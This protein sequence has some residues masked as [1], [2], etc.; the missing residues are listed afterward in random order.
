MGQFR[1]SGIISS[2]SL[3]S[4]ST[5]YRDLSATLAD[6]LAPGFFPPRFGL[7]LDELVYLIAAD[8]WV[9]AKVSGF[10]IDRNPIL[11]LPATVN[12]DTIK[13]TRKAA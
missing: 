7:A 11:Q 4:S 10:D 8:G 12:P 6:L 5:G 9:V 3:L 1:E 13:L 2:E